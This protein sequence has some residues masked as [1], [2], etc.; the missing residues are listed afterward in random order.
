M[1]SDDDHHDFRQNSREPSKWLLA[2]PTKRES[3]VTELVEDM[4]ANGNGSEIFD[5]G[6]EV[7]LA[8]SMGAFFLITTGS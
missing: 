3:A 7:L 1:S 8:A 4:A 2:K 6:L 5:D